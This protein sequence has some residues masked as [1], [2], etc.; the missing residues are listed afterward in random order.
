MM[1]ETN[2]TPATRM[3]LI[4]S[5]EQHFNRTVITFFT[6]AVHPVI[7]DDQDNEM[8]ETILQTSDRNR[9]MILVINSLGGSAVAAE[10]IIRTCRSYSK[11]D[12]QVIVP[13][14]AKSAATM[15]CFGAS[16]L[17][18]TRTSELGPIDPQIVVQTMEGRKL[19]GVYHLLEAYQK[20]F[21]EAIR[22]KGNIQPFLQQLDRFDARDIREYKKYIELSEDIAV[23][24]LKTGMM[25]NRSMKFIKKKIE[26]FLN[27]KQTK[28]HDR[29]IF[30]EEAR[31]LGLSVGEIDTRGD[32]GM[33][34][35]ELYLRS[36]HYVSSQR[37]AKLC[38]SLTTSFAVPVH[39]EA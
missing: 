4:E 28:S 22:T 37:G 31:T 18:M 29:P 7:I 27:P 15:I 34:L 14:M 16:R 32:I 24:C 38:E 39:N 3:P 11:N 21:S 6:S 36:N 2:Q 5:L 8:I 17:W 19:M 33:K 9:K 26:P 25:N 1:D 13:R 20:L 30:F 23:K 12:F 10:R 35:W